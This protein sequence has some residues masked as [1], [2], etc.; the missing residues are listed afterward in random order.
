VEHIPWQSITV[1]FNIVKTYHVLQDM[2]QPSP[3]C[4][5]VLSGIRWNV[6]CNPNPTL[7]PK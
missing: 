3:N 1:P 6:N 2:T 4:Y 5:T 7:N